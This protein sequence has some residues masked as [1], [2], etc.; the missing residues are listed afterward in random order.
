MSIREVMDFS[1]YDKIFRGDAMNK[2]DKYQNKD[3][4]CCY[5]FEPNPLGYCW[6]YANWVDEGKK[7]YEEF[8]KTH[9]EKCD[10]WREDE[11]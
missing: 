5:P 6:G 4:R 7:D 8:V 11:E 2:Y 1:N 3:S 10:K 9:C